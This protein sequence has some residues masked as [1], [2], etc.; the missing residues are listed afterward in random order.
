[1]PLYTD[2]VD[3]D[4]FDPNPTYLFETT[5]DQILLND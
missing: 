4:Y 1:M 3:P 5:P 2:N